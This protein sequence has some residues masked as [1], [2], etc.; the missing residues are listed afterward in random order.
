MELTDA[1]IL[2]ENLMQKHGLSNYSFDFIQSLHKFGVCNNAKKIIYLSIPLVKINSTERVTQTIL[3]EIAHALTP[4]NGHNKKWLSMARSIG[5]ILQARYTTS[6]T[7]VP[8][9]NYEGKCVSCGKIILRYRTRRLAC[10]VCC[11]QF[12]EGK[13]DNKYLFSWTKIS[14]AH[15]EQK[16]Y[17]LQKI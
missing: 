11:R 15:Q 2:A 16:N 5:F 3:H 13:F 7:V 1:K 8:D 4:G 9:K 17:P 14:I 10:G 6:N 12:S